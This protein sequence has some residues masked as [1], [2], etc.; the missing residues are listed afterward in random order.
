M[1]KNKIKKIV[2]YVFTGLCVILVFLTSFEVISATKDS[3][4]PAIFGYS[5]SYVPTESMEPEIEAGEYIYYKKTTF[6]DVGV[7]DVIIYKSKS[8]QMKGKYIVHR[9][10]EKHD[11]YLIV[12]GDNNLINDSEHV[13]SDM[14]YGKYIDKVEILNFITRG[15]SV[16]ALF[17]ILM[18]LFMVL[19][20]LQFIAV[21]AKTK[22]E[23]IEKKLE[24]DKQILLEQMK[25]EILKEELEKL[26]NSKKME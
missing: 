21:F 19:L 7:E 10:V 8:G 18:V 24:E 3:R 2:S 1:N 26:R 23:E 9:I 5:I 12:K 16:N 17:F 6:D 15:L 11:D 25:Q 14:I 22:K 20:V 13:T 4:P